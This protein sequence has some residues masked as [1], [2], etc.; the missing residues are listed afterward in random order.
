[1]TIPKDLFSY[2]NDLKKNNER[3]WFNANK[4]VFKMH[5]KTV[6]DF[7]V[8]IESDLQKTDEIE[9]HRLMRIYRD[10]RFSKDKTPYKSRFAGNFK[11]ATLAK[12]GGYFLNI[13]PGNCMVGGGFYA[14]NTDDLK[15]I[16]Q[17]FE[18]D[19]SEIRAILSNKTFKTYFGELKGEELKT[20][21]RG[22]DPDHKAIDLIR[23]KS[24]YA[25]RYFSDNEV[26][27][28]DFGKKVIE[29]YT[30]LRPYFDF[31]SDVL[32]TNSNGESIL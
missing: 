1:M 17:E 18:M 20:A 7:F 23:K 27:Q 2:L 11:R 31:M 8:T 30:A 29:T 19:D 26:Q 21:P 16:R 4:P 10:V 12:R 13:E 28:P 24:F 3:D 15:R 22:F 9:G 32:T 25:A 14:P 6:K 5:E